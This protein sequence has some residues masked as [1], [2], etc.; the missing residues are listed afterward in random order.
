MSRPAKWGL[1]QTASV[2]PSHDDS[3]YVGL[4]RLL[5][6]LPAV[7]R[8]FL[9]GKAAPVG[10]PQF[11][12]HSCHLGVICTHLQVLSADGYRGCKM[13]GEIQRVGV[14]LLATVTLLSGLNAQ[15]SGGSGSRTSQ[16]RMS[17]P[18]TPNTTMN[19]P[20]TVYYIGKVVTD[21]GMAPPTSVGVLRV[22]NGMSRRMA[23][24]GSDG[25]F[26]F[27][28]GNQP[29]SQLSDATDDSRLFGADSQYARNSPGMM[30]QSNPSSL[31]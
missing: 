17:V 9:V 21:T 10:T 14:G 7:N 23:F 8:D 25:S 16:P 22:C 6:L 15:Q 28:L 11:S 30:S 19:R 2:A 13:R 20:Q 4:S 5:T 24:T 3:G 1:L 18:A 12:Q 31:L 26:S 29:N 27:M